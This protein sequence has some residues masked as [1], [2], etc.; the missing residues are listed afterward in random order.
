MNQASKER[1]RPCETCGNQ[2]ERSFEV[3]LEGE[4]YVFDCFECAIQRLAPRCTSCGV[5][6]VGHGVEAGGSMYCCAHC[7]R[8][9][10]IK[11]LRDHTSQPVRHSP[12]H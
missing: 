3:R 12:G 4:A 5:A 8:T 1:G 7:A 6:I 9:A 2:Y 11:G 10:G